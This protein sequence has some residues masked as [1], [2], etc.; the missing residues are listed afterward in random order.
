MASRRSASRASTC[1]TRRIA[2]GVRSRTLGDKH[3]DDP[4]AAAAEELLQ[5]GLEILDAGNAAPFGAV[6]LRERRVVRVGERS[7]DHAAAVVALL[8][9]ALRAEGAVA[10]DH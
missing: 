9:Q 6:E 7:A 8:A 3:V 4:G 1:P 5:R 2:C 10:V